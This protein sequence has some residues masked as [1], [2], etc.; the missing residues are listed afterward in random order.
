M[1]NSHV[2]IIGYLTFMKKLKTLGDLFAGAQK[3]VE[4]YSTDVKR[5]ELRMNR[6][7]YSRDPGIF[8]FIRLIKEWPEFVGGEGS[9]LAQNT[10]PLKYIKGTLVILTRHQVFST[11]LSY[12][13]P[14][15]IEK[16]KKERPLYF[17]NLNKIS[18]FTNESFF[19]SKD[20]KIEKKESL[21]KTYHPF[22]P[23]FLALQ[24]KANEL[25]QEGD[26]P[27]FKE[28]FTKLLLER[29]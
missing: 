24:D 14:V 18:F 5:D 7:L 8:D 22:S 19:I 1:H 9:Y 23:E 20:L 4:T 15:L 12:L 17:S 29:P 26:D 3:E 21:K 2:T 13:A 27:E 25:F 16:L 6:G 11:E 10:C 28:I